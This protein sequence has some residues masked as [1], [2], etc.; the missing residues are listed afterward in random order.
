MTQAQKGKRKDATIQ[1]LV[2]KFSWTESLARAFIKQC[3]NGN[4][5]SYGTKGIIK[6]LYKELK[7]SYVSM[8]GVVNSF[9]C[10]SDTDEGWGFWSDVNGA[11]R[12][13]VDT[14]DE[15]DDYDDDSACIIFTIGVKK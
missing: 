14:M 13:C 2:S 15:D 3:E 10:W 12:L 5:S 9:L 7:Q 11:V 6:R 1:L 8:A 4:A